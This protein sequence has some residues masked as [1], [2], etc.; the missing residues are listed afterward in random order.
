MRQIHL[1]GAYKFAGA[2]HFRPEAGY[3]CAWGVVNRVRLGCGGLWILEQR[4]ILRCPRLWRSG[5]F[6]AAGRCWSS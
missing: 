2:E 3:L 4:L 1:R 5:G 6:G